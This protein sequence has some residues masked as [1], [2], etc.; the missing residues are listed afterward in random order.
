MDSGQVSRSQ[1]TGNAGGAVVCC[2]TS[3]IRPPQPQGCKSFPVERQFWEKEEGP[4]A[5]G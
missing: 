5:R 4:Q 3:G 1:V 2:S